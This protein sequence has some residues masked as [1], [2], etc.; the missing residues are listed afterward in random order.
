[1]Q[2]ETPQTEVD[3]NY[4]EFKRILP[5][6]LQRSPGKYVVMHGGEIAKEL[7]TFG[8]AARYGL[9]KFGPD[10]FSVQEVTSQSMSLGYHSYALYKPS[11]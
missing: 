10:E 1:M 7:D 8:D 6:L 11:N 3:R 5:E 2:A 4:E 9:E